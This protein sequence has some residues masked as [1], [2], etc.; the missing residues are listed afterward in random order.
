MVVAVPLVPFRY[1]LISEG[2]PGPAG[3]LLHYLPSAVCALLGVAWLWRRRSVV[4]HGWWNLGQLPQGWPVV[5]L[6]VLGLLS[7][8]GARQA[9]AS[10]AK[11]IYYFST[12]GLLYL[13][14]VDQ[15]RRGVGARIVLLCLL[16]TAYAVAAYGLYEF[17]MGSNPLYGSSFSGDSEAYRRLV[18]DP[19]FER[20]ILSTVGHPVALGGYL[21]LVLPV[22][23]AGVL[24]ATSRRERTVLA[25][26]TA[27]LMGA[28]LL[29]FS[30][31]AW[32]AG[33]AGLGV[34]L[35]L[36]GMR[37]LLLLPA[38]LAVIVMAVVLVGDSST[39]TSV[40]MQR[41]KDAYQTYLLD[42][43][44]TTRG[45]GYGYVA[46]IADENPLTGLGTGMYRFR[47]YELRRELA[48]P[49]PVGVL[50][51]PDNMYLVWL[52]ENG[53]IGLVA[54]VYVLVSLVSLFRDSARD[55]AQP[56]LRTMAWGGI[57]ACTALAVDML[58]VDALY[59]PVIRSAFWILMGALVVLTTS[60]ATDA[61]LAERGAEGP[62][63]T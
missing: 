22:S 55:S 49:T 17:A 25:V 60:P 43:G 16:G 14:L 48:I 38:G 51:T 63:R 37:H 19:W 53:A 27:L 47:A 13:V 41:A 12:G 21:A 33:A 61:A 50:D 6:L 46:T 24:A 23:M 9:G 7:A 8:A 34:L 30:R 29:T 5:V 4:S 2:V 18:P 15:M 62:S 28:L 3:A 45:A 40:A 42:F 59:L 57:G 1:L 54:C 31:G 26:G 11:T 44:R 56:G 10:V 39:V 52:A 35:W 36:R 58:T 20:R 32:L